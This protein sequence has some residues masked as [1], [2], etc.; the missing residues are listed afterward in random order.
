MPN[1]F[2]TLPCLDAIEKRHPKDTFSNTRIVAVQHLLE[3]TGSLLQSLIQLGANPKDIFLLGKCYSTSANVASRIAALGIH[4]WPGPYPRIAGHWHEA[5]IGAVDAL[6]HESTA[7]LTPS[8]PQRFLIVDDGGYRIARTPASLQ[9]ESAVVAVEQTT[10]G[11]AAAN[12]AS[13]P[14][15]SV[16][17]AVI[18]RVIESDF[19]AE[20]VLKRSSLERAPSQSCVGIIGFGAIGN[21]LARALQMAGIHFVALDPKNGFRASVDR[22]HRYEKPLTNIFGCTGADVSPLT[23]TLIR[24]RECASTLTLASCSSGD[25]EFASLLRARR[26]HAPIDRSGRPKN[27][28]QT[29]GGCGVCV[30][31]GGFPVNFDRSPESVPAGKIQ[32]TRAL[33]LEGA[34][35]AMS[36]VPSSR[37][38]S[39]LPGIT[40][41]SI[42]NAWLDTFDGESWSAI[43][44]KLVQEC[45][46]GLGNLPNKDLRAA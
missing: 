19:I 9:H 23:L 37:G 14:V 11:L 20:Q 28:L 46:E 4:V 25:I 34:V 3:T 17:S 8:R 31:N 38:V 32:L 16:A 41:R 26:D 12:T 22:Y 39:T 29:I 5:M 35:Q 21:A 13:F 7:N 36:V 15:I 40:E 18:K 33:L 1:R 6:W 27:I 42:L 44:G 45:S 30:L 2:P 24:S 43:N 10:S